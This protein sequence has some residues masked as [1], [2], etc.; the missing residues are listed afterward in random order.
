MSGTKLG[1]LVVQLKAQVSKNEGSISEL[2][3]SNKAMLK[4]VSSLEAS[5]SD[6]VDAKVNQKMLPLSR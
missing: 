1:D 3:D 4:T 5:I 6:L 2:L